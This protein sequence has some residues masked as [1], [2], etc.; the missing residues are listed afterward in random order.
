MSK[1]AV[2][3]W[4]I[5]TDHLSTPEDPTPEDVYGAG[6]VGPGRISPEIEARLRAGEG[7]A[8]KLY[9]DDGELYYSGRIIGPAENSEDAASDECIEWEFA[10]L[11]EFGTP[12]AGATD[13]RYWNKARGEWESL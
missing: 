7:E 3:G 9:D 10:P 11:S 5:D 2:Y 6:S 13:I 8:F 12:N 4:I 1:Y